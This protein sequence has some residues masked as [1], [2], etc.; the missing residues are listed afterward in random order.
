M[1]ICSSVFY[2]EIKINST[3]DSTSSRYF[4]HFQKEIDFP[5]V[6]S[7]LTSIWLLGHFCPDRVPFLFLNNFLIFRWIRVNLLLLIRI[8]FQ[9]IRSFENWKTLE[10]NKSVVQLRRTLKKE[11]KKKK[12]RYHMILISL[13]CRRYL[14]FRTW[15]SSLDSSVVL[16]SIDGILIN[17]IFFQHSTDSNDTTLIRKYE[18]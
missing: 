8:I 14:I 1:V 4:F 11:K 3:I 16:E 6:Y 2:F 5:V 10:K 18:L 12:T 15:L 7:V 9:R 13:Q 17:F